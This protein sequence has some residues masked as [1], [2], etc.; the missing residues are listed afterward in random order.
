M[1]NAKLPL[2]HEILA[3][4]VVLLRFKVPLQTSKDSRFKIQFKEE[5]MWSTAKKLEFTTPAV[6]MSL[7][8]EEQRGRFLWNKNCVNYLVSRISARRVS[9]QISSFSVSKSAPM[10]AFICI[11]F[12][13]AVVIS[14]WASILGHSVYLLFSIRFISK[15]LRSAE[16][17]SFILVEIPVISGSGKN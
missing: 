10:R 3:P 7:R 14:I 13:G 4:Y 2:N 11:P 1:H 15:A 5:K 9:R 16:S 12:A 6:N 17:K 8:E